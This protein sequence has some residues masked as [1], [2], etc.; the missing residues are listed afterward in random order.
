MK[1][2]H[3][4]VDLIKLLFLKKRQAEISALETLVHRGLG[5]SENHGLELA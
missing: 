4:L 3:K 5:S 1:N 2:P